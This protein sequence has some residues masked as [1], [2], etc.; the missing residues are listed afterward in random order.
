M[1]GHEEGPFRQGRGARV[2]P[3][4]QVSDRETWEDGLIVE[5]CRE[6]LRT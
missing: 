5:T 1:Q 6:T 3:L 4:E 2:L